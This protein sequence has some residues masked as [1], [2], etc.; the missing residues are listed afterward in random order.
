MTFDRVHSRR[1]LL[2]LADEAGVG[3]VPGPGPDPDRDAVAGDGHADDDLREVVA[4]VLGLA[5]GAEPCLARG[6]LAA[7]GHALPPVIAGNVLVCLFRLEIGRGG[8]EEKQVYFKA[9]EVGDLVVCL[10]GQ[11]RL[12]LQG[13]VHDPV[14][15]VVA[16]LVQAVDVHVL[17]HPLGARELGRRGQGAVGDQGEQDPPGIG[18]RPAAAAGPGGQGAGGD[19]VQAEPAPQRVQ[20]VRAA[21]RPGRG[22]RQ[23]ARLRCRQGLGRV[24]Q[25]GQ[26]GHQAPDLVLVDLVLAAEVVQDPRARPLR[27]RVPLVAGQLQVADRPGPGGPHGRLHVGHAP[28]PTGR[29]PLGQIRLF[30][31]AGHC[32]SAG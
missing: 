31:L 8:I 15:G 10:L 6:A 27:R 4:G 32:I 20:G 2:D 16:G 25:P 11:D 1:F 19:L 18:V 12:G 5:V 29:P 14:A 22:N 23:L 21:G 3:G 28:E 26:R 17:A 7:G 9:E 13:A 24:Q 30:P